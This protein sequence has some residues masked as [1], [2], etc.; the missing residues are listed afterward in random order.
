VVK[1]TGDGVLVEFRSI[2]DA[3]QCAVDLQ[4]AMVERNA[5][6]PG[7]HRIEFR[8]GIHLGDV[9]EE[10][11]GDLMGTAV[12]VAARL[13]GSPRPARFASPRTFTAR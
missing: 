1:W 10:H 6:L 2:V 3:V 5:G 8:I 11:D 7:D 12:N 9:V 13:E 4:T